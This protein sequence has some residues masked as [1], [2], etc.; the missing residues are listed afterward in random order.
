MHYKVRLALF[1]FFLTWFLKL[2]FAVFY[3]AFQFSFR[4]QRGKSFLIF[5]HRFWIRII[6]FFSNQRIYFFYGLV[7]NSIKQQET[8]E[9][10]KKD[11]PYTLHIYI[12][13]YIIL[14]NTRKNIFR[15]HLRHEPVSLPNFF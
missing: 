5:A 8:E 10:T 7:R 12:Y 1:P 2:I 9:Q 6:L 11:T 15:F 3:L 4:Q 13:V 14:S